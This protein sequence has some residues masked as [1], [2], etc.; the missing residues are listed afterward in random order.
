[1]THER[2]R[3]LQRLLE[4]GVPLEKASIRELVEHAL[5]TAQ[6]DTPEASVLDLGVKE[7]LV[8]AID[9]AKGDDWT[10]EAVVENG[11]VVSV[12]DVERFEPEGSFRP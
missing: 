5:K 12:R 7:R 10:V 4:Q 6:P 11:K 3:F 9:P 2:A 8:T 1:M